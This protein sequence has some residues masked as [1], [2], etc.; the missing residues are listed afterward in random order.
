VM[1]G[2]LKLAAAGALV[3]VIAAMGAAPLMRSVIYGVPPRD[4]VV[5]VAVPAVLIAAAL[6]ASCVPAYRATKVDPVVALRR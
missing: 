6:L 2:G 4:A 5:F 3:G 1:A